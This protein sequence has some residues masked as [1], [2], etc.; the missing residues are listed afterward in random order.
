[1]AKYKNQI[2]Y[3]LVERRRHSNIMDIRVYRRAERDTD[4]QLVII[5]VREKLCIANWK[6]KESKQLK[7]EEKKNNYIL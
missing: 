4:H 7:F 2:D 3:V 5:K 6:R 1:M